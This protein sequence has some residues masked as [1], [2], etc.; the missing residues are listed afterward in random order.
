MLTSA[1][2]RTIIIVDKELGDTIM[3]QQ[4]IDKLNNMQFNEFNQ[5]PKKKAWMRITPLSD[6]NK[7]IDTINRF[8]NYYSDEF[9]MLLIKLY[10]YAIKNNL[11]ISK[12]PFSDSLYVYEKGEHID[13]GYKPLNSLRL[14]DH[15]NWMGLDEIGNDQLNCPTVDGKDYGLTICKFNGD[16]Y[17]KVNI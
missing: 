6:A 16:A 11:V 3:K 10:E 5:N 12:S 7:M 1:V 9:G 15:W 2:N 14:A 17:E 13:W 8:P 4:L